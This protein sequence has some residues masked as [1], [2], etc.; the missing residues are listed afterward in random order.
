MKWLTSLNSQETQKSRETSD[1]LFVCE[2]GHVWPR[3]LFPSRCLVT[4]PDNRGQRVRCS[5]TH[6]DYSLQA[7]CNQHSTVRLYTMINQFYRATNTTPY[8]LPEVNTFFNTYLTDSTNCVL[9]RSTISFSDTLTDTWIQ[10]CEHS[11][12][13][14]THTCTV[15]Q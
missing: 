13:Y 4:A 2:P 1:W 3:T 7:L 14:H 6:S 15:V 12:W 8:W 5:P 11:T 9:P 10:P